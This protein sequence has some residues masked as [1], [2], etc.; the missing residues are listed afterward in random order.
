MLSNSAFWIFNLFSG[1]RDV[2]NIFPPAICSLLSL[3]P[4]ICANEGLWVHLLHSCLWCK[5]GATKSAFPGTLPTL[6]GHWWPS[7]QPALP[8]VVRHMHIYGTL[9]SP[10]DVQNLSP[11]WSEWVDVHLTQ[12]ARGRIFLFW[13]NLEVSASLKSH[14]CQT[15][16]LMLQGATKRLSLNYCVFCSASS[17]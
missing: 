3:T 16:L 13:G 5:Q 6:L 10:V 1:G 4:E 12:D 11:N 14:N 17:K 2:S 8:A 15:S 9:K 7:Q